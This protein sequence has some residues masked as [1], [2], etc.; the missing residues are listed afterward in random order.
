MN[1]TII[2]SPKISYFETMLKR[3]VANTPCLQ[4]VFAVNDD[5]LLEH[6]KEIHPRSILLQ[7][8]EDLK[9]FDLLASLLAGQI[10]FSKVKTIEKDNQKYDIYTYSIEKNKNVFRSIFLISSDQVPLES[11]FKSLN[12]LVQNYYMNLPK[13]KDYQVIDTYSDFLEKIIGDIDHLFTSKEEVGVVSHFHIQDLRNYYKIMSQQYTEEIHSQIKTGI[14]RHLKKGDQL[15]RVN[16]ISYITYSHH[17]DVDKVKSRFSD[18][19]FQLNTLIIRYQLSFH[20]VDSTI[21]KKRDFW[22]KIISG[23]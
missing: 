11:N 21:F 22:D 14:L 8:I 1:Q 23:S 4:A 5:I 10:R 6:G 3:Y 9:K 20:Q 19:F 13:K 18:I 15:Y 7:M 2:E 12:D 16:Q 17:C